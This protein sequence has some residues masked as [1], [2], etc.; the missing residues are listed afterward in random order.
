MTKEFNHLGQDGKVQMEMQ[1][2]SWSSGYGILEDKYGI[3]WM[4]SHDDGRE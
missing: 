1:E 4:F 3:E 2:T